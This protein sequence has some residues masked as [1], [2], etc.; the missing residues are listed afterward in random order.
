M[1]KIPNY[2]SG[3]FS[4]TPPTSPWVVEEIKKEIRE[5]LQMN[6]YEDLTYQYL[7]DV[8]EAVLKGHL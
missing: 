2:A 4:S 1:W 8:T 3:K 5:Y 7:W 6:E